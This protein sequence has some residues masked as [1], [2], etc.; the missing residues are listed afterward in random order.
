[1]GAS[2]GAQWG[3]QAPGALDQPPM[4]A[5]RAWGDK[6]PLQPQ[7]VATL[8]FGHSAHY[9]WHPAE[10]A[11]HEHTLLDPMVLPNTCC[12]GLTNYGGQKSQQCC[13][14]P[15]PCWWPLLK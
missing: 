3:S 10:V 8:P 15:L 6:C 1:M 12:L 4:V 11:P 2:I 14:A 9:R 7:G 5:T 13:C